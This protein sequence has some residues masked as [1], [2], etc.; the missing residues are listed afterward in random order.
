M[1]VDQIKDLAAT[2][3]VGPESDSGI[4]PPRCQNL[5]SRVQSAMEAESD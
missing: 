3:S 1:S 2:E 5:L 4:H